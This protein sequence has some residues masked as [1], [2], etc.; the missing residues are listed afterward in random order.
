MSR[1]IQL[2]FSRIPPY[3][4]LALAAL[5]AGAPAQAQSNVIWPNDECPFATPIAGDG[6][7]QFDTASTFVTT[8][9]P[10]I[11]SCPD[12]SCSTAFQGIAN[13]VWFSW[14]ANCTGPVEMK[15]GSQPD[16]T[17]IP[18]RPDPSNCNLD[19]VLAVYTSC[20]VAGGGNPIHCCDD[21]CA[22]GGGTCD[23]A[24]YL[25]F[26]VVCGQQYI[27]RLGK[28]PG[29]PGGVGS[30][31]IHCL[32]TAC[33]PPPPQSCNDCCGGSPSYT[34]PSFANFQHGHVAIETAEDPATVRIFNLNDTPCPNQASPSV[35]SPNAGPPFRWPF[36][37]VVNDWTQAKLGS[38]FGL[39]LDSIG[40]IYVAHTTVYL[41]DTIGTVTSGDSSTSIYKLAT[42]TPLGTPSVFVNL[43]GG[44][45]NPSDP[46]LGNIHFSC[47]T[48]TLYASHLADGRI[49]RVSSAGVVLG[50][51]DHATDTVVSGSAPEAGVNYRQYALLG[52][53]VW[54]VQTHNGRLYYS[55]WGQNADINSNYPAPGL[56]NSPI[57]NRV[58]SV[59]LNAAGDFVT[60]TRRQEIQLPWNIYNFG[61]G[62][63]FSN[64]VSDI[65]FTAD[66][67]MLV[68]ERSMI[69]D[70]TTSAHRSRATAFIT[71]GNAWIPS[72]A[73]GAG[74]GV[75]LT[76]GDG[77]TLISYYNSSGGVDS[78]AGV[79]PNCAS[80]GGRIWVST[81][82]CLTN[83]S[84]VYG[85]CGVLPTGAT[86]SNNIYIDYNDIYN[87]S[88]D[89][90]TLGDVEIP[91]SRGCATINDTRILCE[92]TDTQPPVFT[93]NYTYTF[94]FTNNTTQPIQYLFFPN[95]SGIVPLSLALGTPV[96]PGGTSPPITVTI[97]GQ[98][99]GTYCFDI[100]FANPEIEDCCRINHCITLPDC[101][102]FQFIQ[103]RVLCSPDGTGSY[104]FT[105]SVQNLGALPI[106]EL[107]IFPQPI[108]SGVTATPADFFFASVP[109]AGVAG[110][111]TTTITGATPGQLCMR[112]S[113]HLNGVECCSNVECIT[114]PDCGGILPCPAD[115]NHDGLVNSQ[116][117]F[118]F[119]TAFFGGTPGA[120]F[121][122]DGLTNS[123]DFFD[124]LTAFFA[125]CP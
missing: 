18:G 117:F 51:F 65:S 103:S 11:A 37:A 61:F 121:N 113:V 107:H 63:R 60:G 112:I 104:Q 19:T 10:P 40:N 88:N 68:A 95:G 35:W 57:P 1:K 58:W 8:S 125:G 109:F 98:H 87:G 52:E 27:I 59:A 23:L 89:K 91:C 100:T 36:G 64:P 53:R 116:D 115:L 74:P 122:G 50:S 76:I 45:S 90:F 3:A 48:G 81:D 15:T 44:S 120:D 9:A 84:L 119:L 43:P 114:L 110:P 66:C 30:L 4:A 17:P 62:P 83:P 21:S 75:G 22:Q 13:D 20:P 102:C 25:H 82:Q 111:F 33:P 41:F 31:K 32:G 72:A 70:T 7:W 71:S 34:D 79:S 123:Q 24:S 124:F 94:T 96:P 42:N 26:D 47:A 78:D 73:N 106:N 97:T 39:T 14:T 46:G 67:Q 77:S 99:P 86:A 28:K 92:I 108:G 6:S 118:D 56:A 49:Y 80:V 16:D 2:L 29:T 69:D 5:G 54:A 85:M 55:V 38:V 101:H 12:C 105:F 93:G